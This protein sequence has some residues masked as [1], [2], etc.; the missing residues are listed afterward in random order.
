MLRCETCL[1]LLGKVLRHKLLCRQARLRLLLQELTSKLFRADAK[2]CRLSGKLTLKL[3]SR[4]TE[5]PRKLFCALTKLTCTKQSGL[6]QLL[7]GQRLL[8]GGLEGALP[9]L[10]R[11]KNPCLSQLLGRQAR[12]CRQLLC[13][14]TKL[15][16]LLR[17][18]GRQLLCRKTKLT[19]RLRRREPGLRALRTESAGKLR[20]LLRP[21]LLRFERRLCALRGRLVTR[22]THLRRG[23]PLLLQDVALEFLLGNGLTATAK[24]TRSDSLRPNTLLGDR[25]LTGNIGQ[26]L[27][28]RRI[29]ELVHKRCNRARL[30]AFR[31]SCQT[32]DALPRRGGAQCSCLLQSLSRLRG[33]AP[34][35]CNGLSLIRRCLIRRCLSASPRSSRNVPCCSHDVAN[36]AKRLLV[37]TNAACRCLLSRGP[38]S[39]RPGTDAK[40][41]VCR[42]QPCPKSSGTSSFCCRKSGLTESLSAGCGLSPSGSDC[43]LCSKTRLRRLLCRSQSG[44]LQAGR[45]TCGRSKR[46]C[47]A[48][49][50]Q[51]RRT[52]SRS[53]HTRLTC[54]RLQPGRINSG[55]RAGGRGLCR[56]KCTQ[57]CLAQRLACTLH[58][59]AGRL[60]CC[61][62]IQTGLLGRGPRAKTGGCRFLTRQRADAAKRRGQTGRHIPCTLDDTRRANPCLLRCLRRGLRALCSGQLPLKGCTGQT[63]L[64]CQNLLPRGVDRGVNTGLCPAR[65]AQCIKRCRA[66]HGARTLRCCGKLRV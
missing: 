28:N 17:T 48:G 43:G 60:N 2:L 39:F 46:T 1:R 57:A 37:S 8:T 33:D 44:L 6:S 15:T 42:T 14:K 31:R 50:G 18:G 26:R 41:G 11:A 51:I 55:L 13:R 64:A 24:R 3:G 59:S 21:S 27:L 34:S 62:S 25:A 7:R 23:P 32:G 49:R 29:F 22:L 5:L 63:L 40:S 20:R 30:E 4:D 10:T 47:T 58:R 45:N 38:R 66:C 12:L 35:I 65:L 61:G 52:R 19:C 9:K 16:L 56:L 53:T 36:A 54:G